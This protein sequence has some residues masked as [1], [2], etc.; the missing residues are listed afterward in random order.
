MEAT[1]PRCRSTSQASETGSQWCQRGFQ[2]G[3]EFCKG[4]D[5]NYPIFMVFPTWQTRKTRNLAGEKKQPNQ[6][7]YPNCQ[8]LEQ[9]VLTQNTFWM[10]VVNFVVEIRFSFAKA[11]NHMPFIPVAAR[12]CWMDVLE[13]PRSQL[14]RQVP[15]VRDPADAASMLDR[16]STCIRMDIQHMRRHIWHRNLQSRLV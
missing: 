4:I 13:T 8:F 2:G 11:S 14:P 3:L 10:W 7:F 6:D 15:S 9:D 1:G 5:V 16:C 12:S